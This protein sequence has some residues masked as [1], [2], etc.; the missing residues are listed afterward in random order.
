MY[1]Q[2]DLQTEDEC[3]FLNE[4]EAIQTPEM[5]TDRYS[6]PSSFHIAHLFANSIYKLV[7]DN[8]LL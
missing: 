4:N 8:S 7:N 6:I 3:K 5:C 2:D 1:D